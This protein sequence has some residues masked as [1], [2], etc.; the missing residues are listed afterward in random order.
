MRLRFALAIGALALLV[1]ATSA[2]SDMPAKLSSKVAW[3]IKD[4][5]FGGWSGLEVTPDGKT[6]VTISD[7]GLILTGHILRDPERRITGVAAGRIR[8]MKHTDGGDFPRYYNDAEGL[9]VAPDGRVFVSF[10]AEHR[11]VEYPNVNATRASTLPIPDAFTRMSNNSS[12]EALAIGPDGALYTLPERSGAPR[13]PYRVHRFDG[14]WSVYG[15]I[16]RIDD[17]LPVGAD[18]GPDGRFYLLER[19][20]LGVFG[21]AT[22]VRRFDMSPQGFTNETELL[23][24]KAG[25]H[26][27]LE[28]LAVWQDEAGVI[29]LTMISDDNFQFF[30]KTEFVE[31][32]VTE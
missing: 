4:E 26:D 30:Q 22:K 2:Q 5:A 23:R 15:R 3:S 9:A 14:E 16:R 6:F 29:R 31:Y 20:F 21:F 1:P 24:T 13:R 8:A 28:G 11:V 7:K 12:L 25:T 17:F 19:M 32:I 18:I 10:E 27:N